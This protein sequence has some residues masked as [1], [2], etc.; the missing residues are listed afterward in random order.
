MAPDESVTEEAIEAAQ[1]LRTQGEFAASLDLTH[2]MLVCAN[3]EGTRMRLLFNVIS[4]AASLDRSETSEA[5][6]G[7]LEKLPDPEVSRVLANLDRAW[8]ETS[9]GRPAHS[10]SLLDM[11][12][13]T[14]LFETEDMRIHNYR[15]CLFKSEALLHLR[16][17]FEAPEWLDRGHELY[18]TVETAS[19]TEE[20]QIFG[21]VE[22]NI[23]IN[24]A[25]C[26]LAF[27]RFEESFQAAEQVLKFG[28]PKWQP[29]QCN[30]WQNAE[31][32]SAACRKHWKS[33]R[34]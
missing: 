31:C 16:R 21:W 9:L 15:L 26:M 18:P 3:D 2:R 5:A 6:M 24:R 34:N 25:N 32:G 28:N 22:P 13:A 4:C 7:E 20:R 23:Q 30:T 29:S 10:L 33:T 17:T 1:K 27:D 12:L 11:S 14:G 8:A 19:S